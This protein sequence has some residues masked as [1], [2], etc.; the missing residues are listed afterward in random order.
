MTPAW[1]QAIGEAD[2]IYLSGGK[3]GYLLG[4]L[5]GAPP[6]ARLAPHTTR[7]GRRG[8]FGRGDGP[9]RTRRRIPG[10]GRALAIRW[11]SGLGFVPGAAVLPHY[12][13]WPEPLSALIALQAP[14]GASVLGIDEETA[15]H[16][17]R[18]S[19]Q[20]QAARA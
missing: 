18:R 13:A 20:V 10:S 15:R 16:R 12:D 6:A 1:L 11:R 7:R 5:S 17:P 9:G 8:M 3:P 4:V 2:L 14:H 19:W